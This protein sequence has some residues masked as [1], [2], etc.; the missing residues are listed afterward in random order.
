MR[1]IAGSARGRKILSV[2]KELPV[3]P[4]SARIRQSLFD[5]VRPRIMGS[6]LLDL[7][8]GTGAVGLEA[9]SRG[10]ELV[11]FVDMDQRC[12]KVIERNLERAGW[13]DKGRAHRGNALSSLTWVA[14]R[15]GVDQ[16]DL[17]FMGPPYVDAQKRTLRY[18][19]AVLDNVAAANLL[20]PGGWIVA[21]HHKKEPL[22]APQGYELFRR[23]RYGDTYLDFV[24]RAG[25]RRS[26]LSSEP[27]TD[28]DAT[29][30]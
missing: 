19:Q 12:V 29:K 24:R 3:R 9:L 10:A 28:P 21:Q 18:S 27:E 1:I 25:E 30:D 4:I 2:P 26:P 14:Y 6:R 15:G 16:F 13:K 22:A 20:A 8:A 11:V 17:V 23:S 7:F 5:I